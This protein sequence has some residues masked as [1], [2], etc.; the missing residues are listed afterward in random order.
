[1]KRG[2][3]ELSAGAGHLRWVE[4]VTVADAN[5]IL[6]VG[7]GQRPP[8][9]VGAVASGRS[10]VAQLSNSKQLVD[11]RVLGVLSAANSLQSPHGVDILV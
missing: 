3:L 7:Q 2:I 1:M 9:I 10:L 5:L 8:R 11:E 4:G 6:A